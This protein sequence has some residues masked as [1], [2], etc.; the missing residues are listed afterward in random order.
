MS[1][2]RD[3]EKDGVFDKLYHYLWAFSDYFKEDVARL[4]IHIPD[5]VIFE[6]KQPLFWYYSDQNG[7]IKKKKTENLFLDN[8]RDKFLQKTSKTN[9]VAYFIYKSMGNGSK[10]TIEYFNEPDF[11]DFL[12]MNKAFPSGILQKFI[13]PDGISNSE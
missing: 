13:D 7:L 10:A 4:H 1:I 12:Y 3:L 6:N 9:I 11:L 2:E 5:T 8:I